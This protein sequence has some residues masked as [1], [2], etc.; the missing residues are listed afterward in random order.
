VSK[1]STH[2][3]NNY[4]KDEVGGGNPRI[5]QIDPIHASKCYVFAKILKK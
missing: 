5:I 2:A 4:Q 3:C 1:T